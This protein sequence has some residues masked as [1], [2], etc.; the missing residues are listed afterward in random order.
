MGTAAANNAMTTTNA[1]MTLSGASAAI[2]WDNEPTNPMIQA[3][4]FGEKN[5]VESRSLPYE[6][7]HEM[8][9][10]NPETFPITAEELSRFEQWLGT[11]HIRVG[12]FT[13]GIELL[14]EMRREIRMDEEITHVMP[15]AARRRI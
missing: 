7:A 11:K 8:L 12:F 9:T 3:S 10:Y 6:V 15:A 4:D 14:V 5:I 13:K 1:N 2:D